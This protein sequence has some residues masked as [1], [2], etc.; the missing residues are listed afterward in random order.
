MV[1]A[2]K[3]LTAEH[4]NTLLLKSWSRPVAAK[5]TEN[6]LEMQTL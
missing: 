2:Y 6:L 3:K 4:S 5:P 1:H